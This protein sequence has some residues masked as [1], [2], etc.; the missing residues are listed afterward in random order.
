MIAFTHIIALDTIHTRV[1]RFLSLKVTLYALLTAVAGTSFGASTAPV[2]IGL[3]EAYSQQSNTAVHAIE[4]G[5]R[6][7]IDE[8][9]QAGGVLDGRPLALKTTDN[10][11]ISA[12]AKDNFEELAGIEGMVAIIGG[13]YSPI[14]VETIPLA[15]KFE[16]PTISVW[17]SADQITEPLTQ[18]SYAFRLSLKDSWGVE[19]MM[20]HALTE[21]KAKRICAI[22]PSTAWGRSGEAVI[23]GKSQEVGVQI[24]MTRWYNWG[25]TNMAVH[26]ALC[27][28]SSAQAIL[29]VANEREASI[30]INQIAS[31][32]ADELLPIVAHWGITGGTFHKMTE[33]ALNKVTLDVI[34]TFSFIQNPRPEAKNLAT[35]VMKREKLSNISQIVSPVGIAQAY[36]MTK[37]IAL[38]IQ[39]AQST[40]GSEI[41]L[42]LESLP[43][44]E[45]AI[46]RYE[47]A[48]TARNHDALGPEQ[49]IFVKFDA[50]GALIPIKKN[51]VAPHTSRSNK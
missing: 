42:A 36:D 9:N 5:I 39:K 14:V 23:K 28:E 41:R 49:V 15:R 13:R 33:K 26:Y 35:T 51:H 21:F 6:I 4:T 34:Q 45:G 29:L 38:A 40:Q 44:Y 2:Y 20:R 27:R 47:P 50:S 16:V 17:G 19:A 10:R 1:A 25:E 48:F 11:G 37:L 30:L 12:L 7:A 31:M 8:I 18:D 24:T 32:P 46:K 3:D 43:P 22:L